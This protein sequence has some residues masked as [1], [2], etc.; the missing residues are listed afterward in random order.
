MSKSWKRHR[1]IQ[2]QSSQ[3][4]DELSKNELELKNTSDILSSTQDELDYITRKKKNWTQ[5]YP[6]TNQILQKQLR[7]INKNENIKNMLDTN[8][9]LKS[10]IDDAD[11]EL[12]KYKTKIMNT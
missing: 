5:K 9:L 11:E 1:K 2:I 10:Q 3:I 8:E 4:K 7:N 12:E 6:K